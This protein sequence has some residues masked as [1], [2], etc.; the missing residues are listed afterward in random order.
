MVFKLITNTLPSDFILFMDNYFS[1]P[2]MA[3]KLRVIKIAIYE[4]MK[5]SRSDLS[6]LLVE[7][8]Q[9][10]VKDIPYDVLAAVV[11][12]DILMIA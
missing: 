5:L 8:K 9:E 6:K 7:M 11:Q 1:E 3:G 2:K 12:N 4:T 10:F